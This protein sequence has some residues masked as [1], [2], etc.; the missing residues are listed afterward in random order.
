MYFIF[1]TFNSSTNWGKNKGID[2]ILQRVITIHNYFY[3]LIVIF[4]K[5]ECSLYSRIWATVRWHIV[6]TN[7]ERLTHELWPELGLHLQP[8][9]WV[10]WGGN[11]YCGGCLAFWSIRSAP[12][13]RWRPFYW[14][15]SFVWVAPEW[16]DENW[17]SSCCHDEWQMLWLWLYGYMG[18]WLCGYGS[19]Y[20]FCQRLRDTFIFHAIDI[21][22]HVGM[23]SVEY[24]CIYIFVKAKLK[25]KI[26]KHKSRGK[27]CQK[28]L[29]MSSLGA[30]W[31]NGECGRARDLPIDWF[32]HTN[33]HHSQLFAKWIL[34]QLQA[35]VVNT[36]KTSIKAWN[37]TPY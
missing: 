35:P 3:Y 19:N 22:T 27:I 23:Q 25:R 33:T 11:G 10:F 14:G 2:N 31:K 9:G 26:R 8:A 13:W 20:W 29:L 4:F 6:A 21:D 30:G 32:L 37:P 24:I 7:N 12:L 34:I 15:R 17:S 16:K 5:A 36:Q 18:I 1:S 28:P